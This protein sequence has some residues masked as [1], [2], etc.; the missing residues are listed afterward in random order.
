MQAALG[1][2]QIEQINSFLQSKQEIANLYY[3]AFA[4]VPGITPMRQAAWAKHSYWLYTILID[5]FLFGKT[6][7]QVLN[8]LHDSGIQTRPL[9]QPM[10]R[11]AAHHASGDYECPVADKLSAQALSLPSSSGLDIKSQSEVIKNILSV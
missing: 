8:Q 1:C 7:R 11:S 9:W 5:E 3:N 6:S 2:A 10:H 4:E